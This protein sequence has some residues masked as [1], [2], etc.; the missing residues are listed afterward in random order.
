[1][2]GCSFIYPYCT[3][4]AFCSLLT[5]AETKWVKQLI[6]HG[7]IISSIYMLITRISRGI[8]Q[9]QIPLSQEKDPQRE[10]E[11]I[12]WDPI[13]FECFSWG[14]W[15]FNLA[16]GIYPETTHLIQDGS[17]PFLFSNQEIYLLDFSVF[18]SI[19]PAKLCWLFRAILRNLIPR[20]LILGVFIR[21][22]LICSP[23]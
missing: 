8:S 22:A 15:D 4:T 10:I 9:L 16:G 7:T 1:M 21:M 12:L 6:T 23:E 20:N 5:W 14:L 13:G 19:T 17:S 2:V 11:L 18:W 3:S